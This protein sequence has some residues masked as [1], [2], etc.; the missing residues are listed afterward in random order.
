MENSSITRGFH[1]GSSKNPALAKAWLDE[2]DLPLEASALGS[3]S[4]IHHDSPHYTT[5]CSYVDIYIY[6]QI[7]IDIYIYTYIYIYIYIDIYRYID[8]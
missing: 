8:I 2:P 7:E 5:I 6:I 4:R 1:K 3:Q